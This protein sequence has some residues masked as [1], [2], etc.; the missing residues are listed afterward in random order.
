MKRICCLF[1]NLK[2]VTCLSD[3]ET[4]GKHV[5]VFRCTSPARNMTLFESSLVLYLLVNTIKVTQNQQHLSRALR[6]RRWSC[7]KLTYLVVDFSARSDQSVAEVAPRA[8]TPAAS[9]HSASTSPTSAGTSSSPLRS[10]TSP[11]AAATAI[12]SSS[13]RACLFHRWPLSDG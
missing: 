2:F 5:F 3:F 7:W 12:P 6:N 11:T 1:Y 10:S 8:R 13:R 9:P 4:N